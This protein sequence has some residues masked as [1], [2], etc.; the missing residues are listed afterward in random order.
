MRQY[1][2]MPNDIDHDTAAPAYRTCKQYSYLHGFN[3]YCTPVHI[4][5][6]DDIFISLTNA[7]ELLTYFK[8]LRTVLVI[9]SFM[10]VSI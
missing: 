1:R 6:G 4:F 8:T 3:E 7:A 10:H 5:T 9:V 2:K